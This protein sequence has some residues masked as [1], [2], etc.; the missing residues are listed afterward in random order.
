MINNNHAKL[1]QKKLSNLEEKL[2]RQAEKS[3]DPELTN[4]KIEFKNL[5]NLYTQLKTCCDKTPLPVAVTIPDNDLEKRVEN[6][7]TSYLGSGLLRSEIHNIVE[8]VINTQSITKHNELEKSVENILTNYLDSGLLKSEIKKIIQDIIKAQQSIINQDKIYKSDDDNKITSKQFECEKTNEISVTD[9]Y[10][11]KIVMEIMK[12]Y[13]ADKTG[14]VDYALESAGGQI[15]SI[16]CTQRF[17]VHTRAVKVMG[18]TLYYEGG[19]PRTVI[20]G[21]TLLPGVC[22]AFQD[23]P[24]YLL[25]KL[26]NPIKITG[27]TLEHAPKSILPNNEIKSAPRKFNVW[28]LKEENDHSPV[29]LGEFEFIDNDESLQYFSINNTQVNDYFEYVELRIHSNHGQ[30]EYTCLYRFRVHGVPV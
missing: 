26:R 2:Q 30:L 19:D 6:I 5:Q 7:F 15:I 13:D 20:Q 29:I 1:F 14:R 27:F 25:I 3:T 18:F 23:F 22:W 12:I 11:R 9:D 10:V 21:H 8:N 4:I 16:R 24:G 17:E 28:G